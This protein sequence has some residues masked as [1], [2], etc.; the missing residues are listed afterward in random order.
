MNNNL[1]I[2]IKSL[3]YNQL[4]ENILKINLPKYKASQVFSWVSKG[5]FDFDDMTNISKKDRILLSKNFYIT[6]ISI[7]AKQIS[8]DGTVKYLFKLQD[9]NF[10]ESVIMKYSFGF[11]I[12]ISTQVGCRMNCDFCAT[13]KAGFKRNLTPGEI[14]S[15]IHAAQND[16]KVKISNIVLM[17]M[18]EPLDNYDNVLKFIKIITSSEGMNLSSRRITISTCGIADKI[19]KLAD[20]NLGIRL[21]I[22]MHSPFD[23]ERNKL[24]P[25]NKKYNIN[26]LLKACKYYIIKTNKRITFEYTLIKN[27]ND[28]KLHATTLAK[29]IKPLICHVNL[30]SINEVSNSKY[31]KVLEEDINKF[32]QILEQQKIPTTIRRTLGSDIDASC[33]QLSGKVKKSSIKRSV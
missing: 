21:S 18:G 7:Q 27:T 32:K 30:I 13:G 24:M 17:G 22:S 5:A 15:Q 10:I 12:C 1:K 2:D 19:Y 25:I 31:N 23:E 29:L 20:E 3:T 28:S 16:L 11:S 33:G 26:D 6:K 4:V 9:G 8:K 14:I